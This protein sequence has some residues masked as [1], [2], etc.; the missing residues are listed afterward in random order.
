MQVFKI[1]VLVFAS[2]FE[3]EDEKEDEK[4]KVFVC[5]VCFV[6]KFSS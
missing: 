3:D 4:G 1:L 5:F 2:I 6:V